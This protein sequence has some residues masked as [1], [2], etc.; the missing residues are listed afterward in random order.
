LCLAYFSLYPLRELLVAVSPAVGL[1]R[2]VPLFGSFIGA[3]TASAA[4]FFYFALVRPFG[5]W[6]YPLAAGF[7][8]LI[9]M[10]ESRGMYLIVP[11]AILATWLLAGTRRAA[12]RSR[13]GTSLAVS[14]VA[15]GFLFV[16][17]PEGRLGVVS[18][19][20]ITSQLG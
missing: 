8:A 2:S 19:D 9:V 17:A 12:V 14:L 7:L 13:L 6:S 10:F 4:G 5:R 18:L 11:L 15:L 16:V 20:T 1:Q 3:D